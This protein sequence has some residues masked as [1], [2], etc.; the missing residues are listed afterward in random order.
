MWSIANGT[1]KEP[2]G[3]WNESKRVLFFL[4][5]C[6]VVGVLQCDILL[7]LLLPAVIPRVR[8]KRISQTIRD[9]MHDRSSLPRS[10]RLLIKNIS[11]KCSRDDRKMTLGG[12]HGHG[13]VQTSGGTCTRTSLD[14]TTKQIIIIIL[15][16]VHLTMLTYTYKLHNFLIFGTFQSIV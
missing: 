7:S 14:S 9:M 3:F 10:S 1:F 8:N 12:L 15:F 6:Q 5:F 13:T 16:T 11:Q 4:Q 2:K